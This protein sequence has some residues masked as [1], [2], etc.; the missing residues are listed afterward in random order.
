MFRKIAAAILALALVLSSAALADTFLVL[1]PND[2]TNEG[3]ALLL[4]KAIGAIELKE[5]A[6]IEATINE[7]RR[8]SSPTF[9][10]TRPSPSSTTT[11]L[12]TP[13]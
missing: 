6:G 8:R 7:P 2:P 9:C 4:L 11:T 1:V 13:D 3:R 5:D 12:W 10:P